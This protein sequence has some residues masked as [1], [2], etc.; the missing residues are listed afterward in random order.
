MPSM[1]G[2]RAILAICGLGLAV[3]IERAR[4]FRGG[5]PRGLR[6]DLD[7]LGLWALNG[8]V[9][10]AVPFATSLAA[11]RLAAE[12]N[13]GLLH[14]WHLPLLAV[15]PL[16]VAALDAWT[17][18]LHRL[19]HG[20]PTLWRIHRVHHLDE[21]LS[22]TTGVRFHPAEVLLSAL[23]RLPLIFGLGLPVQAIVCFEILLL[24]A[25][26]LQHADT[27]LPAAWNR[28]LTT[29]FVTPNFHQVH[30]S[31][32]RHQA[33]SNFGTI[34]SIWDRI[35]GT[36]SQAHPERVVVGSPDAV[37]GEAAASFLGLLALPVLA[38]RTADCSR[39]VQL[40]RSP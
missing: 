3:S 21:H 28:R 8:A 9:L 2:L 29:A 19:Y 33:D 27:R 20:V 15:L 25:S 11:A 34:F 6:R 12:W 4:P 35:S 37:P 40:R 7:H 38:P 32:R 39:A 22:A 14:A 10:Q 16:S 24:A 17:W 36:L 23:G 26:Q 13:W 31:T 5:S 30:H 1:D 18:A